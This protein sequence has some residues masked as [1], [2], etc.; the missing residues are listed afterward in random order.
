VIHILVNNA[1]VMGTP[2]RQLTRDGFEQQIGVNY[3]AHFALTARLKEAL[4]AAPGGGR[5][6]SVASLAHRRGALVLDDLQSEKSYSPMRAYSQSKLA[7]L[8][9]AIELQRRA[10]Q[11]NWNLRSIAVHPGWA[12]TDIINSGIGGGKPGLKATVI[13][14]T[15]ALV[16]QSARDGALSSLYAA[17][18]PEAVGGAYYGTTRFG[19]TRGPPGLA[20]IFPQAADPVTGAR[21]WTLSEKLTGATFS[22]PRP[23][24]SSGQA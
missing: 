17:T 3:L 16:A 24:H 10:Q 2:T 15:F 6:V 18:A 14:R 7:M 13:D 20:R 4:C 12:R 9:F 19:E 8:V 21:L 11:N 22:S 5:V 1:G 23:V